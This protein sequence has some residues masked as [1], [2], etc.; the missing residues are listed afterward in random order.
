MLEGKGAL[1]LKS[2]ELAREVVRKGEAAW[3]ELVEHFGEQILDSNGEINRTQLAEI[4]FNS[5]AERN[6]LNRVTHPRIFQQMAD[7]LHDIEEEEKKKGATGAVIVD[8][9]L[10][11]ESGAT[12]LFDFVLV[13]DSAPETQVERLIRDRGLSAEEAWA[14][15]RSQAAREERLRHAD[16]VVRNDG[17]MEDLEREVERAWETIQ[18]HMT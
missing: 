17:T 2:D 14:R 1:V 5:P 10:L 6:F 3:R 15:I 8:I 7:K 9:P 16:L 18:A 4:V 12:G 11:V 13:I